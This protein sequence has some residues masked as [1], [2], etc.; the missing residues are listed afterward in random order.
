[1][2]L[3]LPTDVEEGDSN[4]LQLVETKSGFETKT[5]FSSK[6]STTRKMSRAWKLKRSQEAEL[7]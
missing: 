3:F 7:L 5:T 4:Q 6:F 1:M 2:K